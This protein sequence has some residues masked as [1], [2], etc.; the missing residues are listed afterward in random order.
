MW[1]K[2]SIITPSFNCGQFLEKSIESVLSQEYP[3]LDYIILDGGSSDNS[4]AIIKKHEARLACWVSESDAGL[5]DAMNKGVILAKGDWIYFLGADD[6]MENC[7][8]EV[9][10][11]L[12]HS[13][14][15]YYGDV[16]LPHKHKT[17]AG[18]FKWH[19][20]ISK[21]INHQSMFYPRRVFSKY[22]F[23]LKYRVYADYELNLRCWGERRFKFQY[24]PVLVATHHEDGLS[25]HQ[26]D[27]I[28]SQDKQLL[29]EKYFGRRIAFRNKWLKARAV[30]G[31]LVRSIL[32][33]S[34]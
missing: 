12:I 6:V 5:Y 21:N 25:H 8:H 24:M 33:K 10:R 27:E 29:I 3:N 19:T 9:A 14:T 1:P 20:L 13:T 31:D 11:H 30:T 2:I 32:R 18:E 34:R 23:N 17:Y 7:L 16:Y 28:F 22:Q 4:L 26:T 15:I